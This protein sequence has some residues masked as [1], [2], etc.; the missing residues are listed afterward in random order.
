MDEGEFEDEDGNKNENE[1]W[2]EDEDEIDN[3]VPA[4]LAQASRSM[5]SLSCLSPLHCLLH[6]IAGTVGIS[7]LTKVHSHF[8]SHFRLSGYF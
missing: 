6:S 7:T 4:Y 2:D 5:P 3:P 8:Q 1:D